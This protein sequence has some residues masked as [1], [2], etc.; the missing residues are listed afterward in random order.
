MKDDAVDFRSTVELLNQAAED[1]SIRKPLVDHI[2]GNESIVYLTRIIINDSVKAD[3][4]ILYIFLDVQNSI[5][6]A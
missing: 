6:K 2:C 1:A 5:H 3:D 4:W